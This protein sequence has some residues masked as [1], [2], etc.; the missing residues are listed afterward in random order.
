MSPIAAATFAFKLSKIFQVFVAGMDWSQLEDE[1]VA[2]S[3]PAA[4]GA[5]SSPGGLRTPPAARPSTPS[6]STAVTLRQ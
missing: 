2:A 6:A 5:Q 4:R 3:T 1:M